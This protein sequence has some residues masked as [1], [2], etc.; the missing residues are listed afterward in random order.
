MKFAFLI[1]AAAL[2]LPVSALQPPDAPL[3]K[4]LPATELIAVVRGKL[5]IIN[6][7]PGV[8]VRMPAWKM[9]PPEPKAK[10]Q[11]P[12]DDSKTPKPLDEAAPAP[13]PGNGNV[14][15]S[16]FDMDFEMPVFEP[17]PPITTTVPLR[18]LK[19]W[20]LKGRQLSESEL[21]TALSREISL[22]LMPAPL[23]AGQP[24]LDPYYAAV[25]RQDLLFVFAEELIQFGDSSLIVPDDFPLSPPAPDAVPAPAPDPGQSQ[26]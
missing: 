15:L 6:G 3:A 8:V 18:Q 21:K 19:A 11:P 23:E 1:P 10:P 16:D 2:L 17:L 12:Q 4:K 5:T 7:S 22:M 24:P 14:E 26:Q 13:D 25:M 20:N 9:K